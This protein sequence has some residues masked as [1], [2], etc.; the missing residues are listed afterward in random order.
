MKLSK[1]RSEGITPSERYL[2]KL[3]GRSFL[4]LWSYTNLHTDEGRKG[5]KGVGHELCDLLVVFGN[6]VIIFSDRYIKFNRSADIL[7]SW[8]RW[9]K[10]AVLK[11]ANQLYGA[12]A[13]L[14]RHPNRIYL[15]PHCENQIPIALPQPESM[16]VHRVA[17]ALGVYEACKE[18]FGGKSLGSLIV[19]SSLVGETHFDLPFHIGQVNP[20]KG[21]V[22]VFEDFTLDAV[23]REVDTIS[24]FVAYLSRKER[25]LSR[26]KSIIIAT[27]EE[28]LLSLYLTR[29]NKNGE[30]DFDLPE[31]QDVLY[32]DE[33]FWEEMVHNPQ[34]R[35]KK[36]A[37]RISY[38]WDRLIEHFIKY[39]S[40]YDLY[41]DNQI[42]IA[43]QEPALRIMASEPRIRRRQL[44][45]ALVNLMKTCPKGK[46]RTRLVYSNDFPDVA[47]LFLI[48]PP[49]RDQ[50][51]DKYPEGRR[52]MLVDYCK[53]A[54]LLA[55]D[56]KYIVGIA[57]EPLGTKGASEDFVTL[58]I[59][60]WTPEM[61]TEAESLQKEF[62]LLL[63]TNVQKTAGRIQEYPDLTEGA[64]GP[65]RGR[66]LNR[67][68]RRALEAMRRRSKKNE[69]CGPNNAL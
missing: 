61:Q 17:V 37:D 28:Q 64:E 69:Q 66:P 54:K 58:D 21:F 65:S 49:L 30:H 7:V 56:A 62:S 23:L 5:G 50:S 42:P 51:Y 15:D 24:D 41:G 6:D 59:N 9:F 38:A 25:L 27:G 13:W 18:F 14:R 33:G 40:G 60:E 35:A 63:D 22:H 43:E 39:G 53:V 26:E 31:D 32:L 47:Y 36:E 34:Y 52:A 29:L 2:T 57:T 10:R 16:R 11:S 12:E 3:C 55:R 68:Q 45:H 20:E 1:P 4:S 48:L 46:G 44:G 8:K 19:D 67:R